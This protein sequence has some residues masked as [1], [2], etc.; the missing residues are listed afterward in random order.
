MNRGKPVQ[1]GSISHSVWLS[2]M[3]SVVSK[4]DPPIRCVKRTVQYTKENKVSSH[5]SAFKVRFCSNKASRLFCLDVY[6]CFPG[7]NISLFHTCGQ[8][9]T[10]PWLQYSLFLKHV[11]FPLV[12]LWHTAGRKYNKGHITRKE[13]GTSVGLYNFTWPDFLQGIYSCI[14]FQVDCG[15][16][17]LVCL[18]GHLIVQWEP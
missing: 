14:P 13:L 9:R 12:H 17:A 6:H 15:S 7:C 16:L 4:K 1:V 5:Y 18:F 3:M 11:E 2:S 8:G 10:A